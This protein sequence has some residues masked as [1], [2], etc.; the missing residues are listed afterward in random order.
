MIKVCEI[1]MMVY[2]YIR[3]LCIDFLQLSIC[4][5]HSVDDDVWA[6]KTNKKDGSVYHVES[7]QGSSGL[8]VH[9]LHSNSNS[10]LSSTQSMTD[11]VPDAPFQSLPDRYM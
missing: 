9:I 5:T 10:S 1:Q 8:N 3:C 6:D 4:S 2:N 11:L 7:A